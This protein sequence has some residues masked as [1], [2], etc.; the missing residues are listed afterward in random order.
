MEVGMEAVLLA[1][2]RGKRQA[3]EQAR[4]QGCLLKQGARGKHGSRH[5]GSAAC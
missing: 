2:T 3:W 5:G 1:K 4:R